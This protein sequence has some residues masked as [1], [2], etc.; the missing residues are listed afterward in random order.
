MLH[1]IHISENG[2]LL[3]GDWGK[4]V[5]SVDHKG[6][7]DVVGMG[8]IFASAGNRNLTIQPLTNTGLSRL[9]LF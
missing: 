1:F 2:A 8:E 9:L 6:C 4:A 7:L 5:G 3:V